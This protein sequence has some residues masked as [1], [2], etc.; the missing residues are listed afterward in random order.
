MS[1]SSDA[2]SPDRL[3]LG[4]VDADVGAGE[5]AH[6]LQLLRRP[7]GLRR[8]A[9]ADDDDLPER[10]RADRLDRRVGGVGRG[11]L[12]RR[13]REHA[14]DVE[15][16]VAVPDHDGAIDVQVE[17]ELLEI[18][19]AVVPGDELGGRPRAGEVLAGDAEP[20]VGLRAEGVDDGVVEPRQIGVRQIAPDLDVAEEPEAGLL[21]DPLE[22]ARDALQLRMVRRDAQPHEPPRRRQPLDHVHLDR[23]FGVEERGRRIEAGRPGPDDR[24][25]KGPAHEG[26]ARASGA[27]A[28][29]AAADSGVGVAFFDLEGVA[30]AAGRARVRVVDREPGCLDRV[31]VVDLGA[32]EV[33]RAERVD[34]DLDAVRLELEVALDG[35]AVEAEPVLEARA[36]AALDRDAQDADVLFLGDQLLDLLA[37]DSVT[38]IRGSDSFLELHRRTDRS[39]VG[40]FRES[41][42]RTD[43][44]TLVSRTVKRF[45]PCFVPSG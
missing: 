18:G 29:A 32:L 43:F 1:C 40:R 35:A 16:D 36:A 11:E 22:R 9:A 4:G 20:A 44:V 19:V 6:L 2:S 30:A 5:L 25:A 26:D 21:G 41:P 33:R 31:D 14:R 27:A 37:A 7:G 45:S 39:N 23:C 24:D 15:S 13:Q 12:L 34:D 28:G 42:G 10:R 3:E 38:V 8:A 17:L